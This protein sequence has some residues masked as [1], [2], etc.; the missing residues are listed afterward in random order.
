LILT[1][2]LSGCGTPTDSPSPAPSATPTSMPTE[3]L[4]PTLTP[5]LTPSPTPTAT[6]RP[7]F[8]PTPL[9]LAQPGTPLP[10]NLEPISWSNAD[11]VSGLA[12]FQ[13]ESVTDLAWMQDGVRLG[14][15]HFDGVSIYDALSRNRLEN[16]P[17]APGVISMAFSPNENFLVLGRRLGSQEEGFA[18]D[19]DFY[20]ISDW[21]HLG[22]LYTDEQAV[23]DLAFSPNAKTFAAAFTLPEI[24]FELNRVILWDTA[25]WEI[26]KT[27]KMGT[28]L[29]LAFSSNGSMLATVPDRYAVKIW[30]MSDGARLHTIHTSFTGAVNSVTFSPD[31]ST[32][33]TGHYDGVIR[34]WSTDKGEQLM[35]I[36]AGEVVDSLAFTPDGSLL[37]SGDAYGDH[38][39]RLWDV[40]TG[41]LLGTLPGHEHAVGQ[42]TFSPQGHMLASASY[43]G[44]VRLWGIR[45]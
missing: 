26:T 8:T 2:I 15:A 24:E 29:N 30:R 16:I 27:L 19:L 13:E 41:V 33:A 45:P 17:S 34:I 25:T 11:L 31:G 7:T 32:L 28:A 3:T 37:A 20:R 6:P 40:A 23:T 42:L 36:Q 10:Q 4:A 21:G 14:V 39:I 18:G 22:V 12:S 5:T 35:E 44:E 43:D 1:L 38:D 9:F